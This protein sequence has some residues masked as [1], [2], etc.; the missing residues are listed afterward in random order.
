MLKT[1]V[2]L[3]PYLSDAG[4]YAVRVSAISG[5]LAE[6]DQK[7]VG[8]INVTY[9]EL[10]Y[11][12]LSDVSCKVVSAGTHTASKL[13]IPET[14]GGRTVTEIGEG[15]FMGNLSLTEVTLPSGLQYVRKN[16]FLNCENLLT[17]TAIDSQLKVIEDGAFKECINLENVAL[18]TCVEVIG[19]EAFY[20]CYLGCE[21]K[22]M[23]AYGDLIEFA[24]LA[25][26]GIG[27]R[28][29]QYTR[30][31]GYLI[32]PE[33]VE[34]I[35]EAAFS[36]SDVTDVDILGFTGVN[37]SMFEY[38]LS[39][40]SVH[41]NKCGAI[42]TKAFKGCSRLTSIKI[43]ADV[44]YIE[45]FAF[46]GCDSLSF[47]STDATNPN[48]KENG[49][50]E[51]EC[52]DGWVVSNAYG[53]KSSIAFYVPFNFGG[54]NIAKLLNTVFVNK[55]FWRVKKVPTPDV[56]LNGIMLEITDA[57]R[58]ASAY[59]IYMN[60]TK[61]DTV[62]ASFGTIKKGYYNPRTDSSLFATE[63]TLTSMTEYIN[64]NHLTWTTKGEYGGQYVMNECMQMSVSSGQLV[65][66]A[67]DNK[68]FNID[69]DTWKNDKTSK[70]HIMSD[71][72]VSKEFYDWF[73]LHFEQYT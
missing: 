2:T 3:D 44:T 34:F 13:V 8:L 48:Y 64:F 41:M 60:D 35:G 69:A 39:L 57:S 65:Y 27:D 67:Y 6:S 4:D 7:S 53:D 47:L 17:V 40:R 23:F 19:N 1:T 38:C 62:A 37:V 28:A 72:K 71:A 36:N 25:L 43:P 55:C 66:T 70:M 63:G 22:D 5:N 52:K 33:T 45:P 73:N 12:I 54:V 10:E 29:F 24:K 46:E 18:P 16:A 61:V 32:I 9:G 42:L 56:N 11:E 31:N 21:F 59:N 50:Y 30:L 58:W 49:I 14:H 68:T 26:Y 20:D 51:F 15:A